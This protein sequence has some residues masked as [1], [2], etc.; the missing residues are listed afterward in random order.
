[1][2]RLIAFLCAYVILAV[3]VCL[4]V[5]SFNVPRYRRLAQEGRPTRATV[6]GTECANHTVFSYRFA[7]GGVTYTG[8]GMAGFGTKECA[9]LRAGD[10]VL[11]YYVPANPEDNLPGDIHERL[12]NEYISV[13]LAALFIPAILVGAVAWRWARA[14]A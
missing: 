14:A 3:V 1:M 8:Q 6:T 12:A 4:A 11:V 13:V 7:V 9:Q 2:A 5:G 10:R